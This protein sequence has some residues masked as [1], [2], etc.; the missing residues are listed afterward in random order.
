M[1]G[2]PRWFHRWASPPYVYRQAERIRP[3][4]AWLAGLLIAAGAYSGLVLAPPDY[5][6]G[7]S[8]RIMYVHV[9]SAYLGMLGYVIMAVASAIGFVWRIKLAFAVATSV[10]PIGASFTFLALV[11]G[12]IWGKPTWGTYWEWGD[13]RLMF[14]LLLLF[15]YLGYMALRAAF[16]ERDKADRVSAILAV[17]GV[18]N[19]PIIHYSVIWWSTLHQGPTISKFGSPSITTNMLV[20]LL[21]ML[22]GFTL[23]FLWLVLNRLQGQIVERE[24]NTRWLQELAEAAR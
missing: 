5:L 16:E 13:A 18:I 1:L 22:A 14:E 4:V 24:R 10:A 12:G 8:F 19:V 6:Q 2:L 9:P 7:D 11:T 15:L 20:P 17:V 23:C 3:W 21:I